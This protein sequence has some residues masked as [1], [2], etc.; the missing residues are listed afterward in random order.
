MHSNSCLSKSTGVWSLL[1][2]L[3][4]HYCKEEI[5]STYWIKPWI[6]K[7]I[8]FYCTISFSSC[9]LIVQIVLSIRTDRNCYYCVLGL[10]GRFFTEVNFIVPQ[11][12]LGSFPTG[13]FKGPFFVQNTIFS[14]KALNKSGLGPD[15]L[16]FLLLAYIFQC[17]DHSFTQ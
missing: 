6:E 16:S 3:L 10:D 1:Q 17:F 9:C 2:W 12:H 8:T 7:E 11:I 14:P 13:L 5:V 15:L 4:Q